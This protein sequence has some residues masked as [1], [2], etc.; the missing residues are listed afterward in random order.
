MNRRIRIPC[1]VDI[2]LIDEPASIKT[3]NADDRVDRNFRRRGPLV[4]RVLEGRLLRAMSL[5]PWLLPAFMPRDDEGR[6][7]AQAALEA[8]LGQDKP[9]QDD[10]LHALVALVD[11]GAAKDRLGIAVQ[12]LVGRL[13]FDDYRADAESYAAAQLVDAYP[14][15][16]P[17]KALWW[18]LSG[19]LQRA[20]TLL[21]KKA[22]D[23][24]HAIHATVIAFHNIVIAV[25]RMQSLRRN[26]G[27]RPRLSA[28][29]IVQQCLSAPPRTLRRV[30]AEIDTPHS[31]RPL[32]EHGLLVFELGKAQKR[33]GAAGDAFMTASWSQCPAH[34]FVPS[35]LMA[36]WR[37]LEPVDQASERA[38]E[39]ADKIA[40]EVPA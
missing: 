21:W 20:R 4:N 10:D 39:T 35:L 15:G 17:L 31:K 18:R 14:R 6:A 3:L 23:D 19:K 34:R 37:E 22:Q 7:D 33:T 11:E 27:R 12:Q 5:G 1:L 24:G 16:N 8:R 28:E 2:A 38:G 13:F 29:T 30:K 26:P 9:W 40:D 36:I 25:E 32:R